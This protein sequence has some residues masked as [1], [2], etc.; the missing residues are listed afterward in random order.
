MSAQRSGGVNEVLAK[1]DFPNYCS[2]SWII[3]KFKLVTI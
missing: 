1:I 2:T 3:E